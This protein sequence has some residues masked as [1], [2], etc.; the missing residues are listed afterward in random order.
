MAIGL[1]LVVSWYWRSAVCLFNV[2]VLL[3]YAYYSL[4]DDRCANVGVMPRSI[5]TARVACFTRGVF[6]SLGSV[7]TEWDFLL[8]VLDSIG[9]ASFGSRIDV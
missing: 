9:Q 5:K 4:P 8:E 3:G 1:V 7:L 6:R 2:L